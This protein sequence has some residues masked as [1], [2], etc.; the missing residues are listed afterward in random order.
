MDLALTSDFQGDSGCP[1]ESM[2]AIA[3]G[4][5]THIHWCHHWNT[6]FLYGPA[7]IRQIARWFREMGLKLLDLHGSAGQEKCWWSQRE[8]ERLAGVDLVSNRIRMTEQLGGGT[9]VMHVPLLPEGVETTP[10]YDPLRRSLD[11]L[12][13]VTRKCGI[14][15]ALE[16]MPHDNFH[17]LDKLLAEYGPDVIGICYDCGHGN[18]GLG[19]GLDHMETLKARLAA[20]HLHDNDGVGDKHWVPFTGTVDARRLSRLLATSGYRGCISLESNTNSI[21]QA[22]R[23]TF[24]ADAFQAAGRLTEMVAAAR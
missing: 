8:Y 16:N 18:I 21:P 3:A 7:E 1:E 19:R 6:D 23:G 20:V 4:G 10:D 22:N 5:F 17:L 11:A 15:L 9:V 13:P 24:V 14:P 2:R 12:T